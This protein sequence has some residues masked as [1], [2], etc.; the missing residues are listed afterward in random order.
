[1][2]RGKTLP[3]GAPKIPQRKK[4]ASQGEFLKAVSE[5]GTIS[6]AARLVGI[7][8]DVHYD[9]M[10]DPAY[11]ARFEVAVDRFSDN[12][13]REAIRRAYEGTEEPVGWHQG[14]PGGY[15]RRYSDTLMI[16][17]LKGAK[18]KKYRERYEVGADPDNPLPPL[19]LYKPSVEEE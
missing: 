4:A 7:S 5:I 17:L 1:M 6:G 14:E 11:A 13:E 16:F 9:W 3:K 19:I 10:Q 15:V 8:R 12:L 2:P 18:P